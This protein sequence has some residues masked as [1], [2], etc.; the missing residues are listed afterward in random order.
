[1]GGGKGVVV[2]GKILKTAS[3]SHSTELSLFTT[4]RWPGMG[5][6]RAKLAVL[7]AE[8]LKGLEEQRETAD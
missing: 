1:M 4:S 8:E 7:G 3:S 2:K 5:Y 6:F